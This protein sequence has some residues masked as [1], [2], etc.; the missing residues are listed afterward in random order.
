MKDAPM[1]MRATILHPDKMPDL[2]DWL[3]PN[4]FIKRMPAPEI[5]RYSGDLLRLWCHV[6]ARYGVVTTELVAWLKAEIGG[7]GAIEIGSG[8]G[9]L[10]HHLGIPATD[11]RC[12][13]MPDVARYYQA[14]RQPTIKYAPNT[15]KFDALEAVYQFR[16]QVVVASWVTEWVD[17]NL[18]V[19][20]NGGSVYGVKEPE[21]L[22][23]GVT[24]I[25]IGNLR[26]HGNKPIMSRRHRTYKYPWLR[27]RSQYPDLDRIFVWN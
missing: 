15:F 26:T 13:E 17:A 1:E 10:A 18:P 20:P 27:S 11:N 23:T 5:S 24:Y 8:A 21:L 25:L 12:Q 14:I 22:D 4:G 7:R 16:P 3:Q 9:D 19:P 6:Y 2:P